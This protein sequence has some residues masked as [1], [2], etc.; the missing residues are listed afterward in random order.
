MIIIKEMDFLKILF[1]LYIFFMTIG[2]LMIATDKEI[3]W[4]IKKKEIC[5]ILYAIG[6]GYIAYILLGAYISFLYY[7]MPIN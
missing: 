6:F 2:I 4:T 7:I 5:I 1:K 3:N